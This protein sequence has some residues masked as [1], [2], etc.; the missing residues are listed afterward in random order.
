MGELSSAGTIKCFVVQRIK[1]QQ[2]LIIS[3]WVIQLLS[4]TSCWKGI[5][6]VAQK[7]R[8]RNSTAFEQKVAHLA[9][10]GFRLGRYHTMQFPHTSQGGEL[11]PG[12]RCWWP[13]RQSKLP[14]PLQIG[15]FFA[16]KEWV[17]E[18]LTKQP[19]QILLWA[20]ITCPVS[21][22]TPFIWKDNFC[23]NSWESS[24][25]TRSDCPSKG[26]DMTEIA[27]TR[28]TFTET[29]FHIQMSYYLKATGYGPK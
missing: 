13:W 1:V 14:L 26:K 3:I 17:T 4:S 12:Y 24:G 6:G 11:L 28:A 27:K 25:N 7:P 18:K 20:R 23:I 16:L 29:A 15:T 22:H 5:P 8:C 9:V 19:W 2:T 21:C 10:E